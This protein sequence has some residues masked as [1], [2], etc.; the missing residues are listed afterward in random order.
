MKE[1]ESVR[2][3]LHATALAAPKSSGVYLWK[4]ESGQIL[5]VGKAKSLRNRLLSYFSS[6]RDVKTRILV[7]RACNIEY[8][9]TDNE[10]E[11]LLL[12]NTLIKQHSP[13]YNINL[14]DGKTYP[15][16]KITHE[17]YP[18]LYRTRRILD[19]KGRYFG[20]FPDVHAV[21]DFLELI[22]R[23]YR[24]RQCKV[25]RKRKTPCLY[26][27]IGR[28]YGPC[29]GLADHAVYHSE[30]EEVAL[31]LD[32]ADG[33]AVK[34]L[35]QRMKEAAG[36]LEFETAARL[37]DGIQAV[38]TLRGQNSVVDL[39]ET[40]RDYIAW[41]SEGTMVTFAVLNMRG[42][43]LIGRDLYRVRSL[44]EE[45]E[46]LPEF[47]MAYY[48]EPARVPPCIFV[49]VNA[50][51]DLLQQWFIRELAVTTQV[52]AVTDT[53][54][55]RRHKAAVSMAALNA[56]EDASRRLKEQGDF[57]ALQELKTVLDLP[58]L[59]SRIEGFD[60]AHI[61]GRLPVASLISFLDGN[62]DRKNYRLFRL[63]STDGVIDDYASMREV[64]ARRYGRL[65]SEDAALPDL[66]LV[67]GGPGQVNAVR[68]ILDALELDIPI[69][70]LAKEDEQIYRPGDSRPLSLPRR[71]DALRLLQRIRDETH[72]FAT[73]RNQKL[74]TR[75]NTT[76]AFES[77]PGIGPAKAVRLLKTFGSL[78]A[79]AAAAPEELTRSTGLAGERLEMLVQA[80]PKLLEN[81]KNERFKRA[82]AG[83]S[84]G[85]GY[86]GT[87]DTAA[88]A[89]QAAAADNVAAAPDNLAAEA[90][91]DYGT[92]YEAAP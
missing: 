4:D 3:K 29:C 55:D 81:R 84:T 90:G 72:R 56:R 79:L 51:L 37:R 22:K 16:I 5:Y 13:R 6:D 42:G 75:E 32:S 43:R 78:E 1:H 2:K 39:D 92:E 34:K 8:I 73:T 66:I 64:A 65:K 10:Y 12:E 47:I 11:A 25:L 76:L 52:R 60:I 69:A 80:I 88:L 54:D 86:S 15:V 82:G 26:Y 41:A 85:G 19:D 45:N 35:E 83:G 49:P 87:T 9:T 17:P 40:A 27:H 70:G 7:S 36:R 53:E 59:P 30:L 21:D 38:R 89:R 58:T 20:P 46:I 31:L 71:S 44:R 18:R 77:L 68:S 23:L 14:K 48:T 50:G 24:F 33:T 67:D 91:S 61:G 62:P 28:C 63:R 74:R 57:P